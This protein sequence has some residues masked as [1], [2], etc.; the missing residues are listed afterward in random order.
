LAILADYLSMSTKLPK[1]KSSWTES[2]LSHHWFGKLLDILGYKSEGEFTYHTEQR[3]INSKTLGRKDFTLNGFGQ[4]LIM[5]ELKKPAVNLEPGHMDFIHFKQA[6]KY[7][8]SHY[9]CKKDFY[10]SPMGVLTNGIFAYLFDGSDENA[11]VAYERSLKLDLL[12]ENDLKKFTNLIQPSQFSKSKGIVH[13]KT[14]QV[15]PRPFIERKRAIG[16]ETW[17]AEKL[18]KIYNELNKCMDEKSAFAASITFF[19]TAILRDCGYIPTTDLNE[20]EDKKDWVGLIKI[21]EMHL[22]S[23][24]GG[25]LTLPKSKF[26]EAFTY[27]E[28]TRWLPVRLDVL[29]ADCLG[30]AY[31]K[32]LH[33]VKG[34]DAKTSYFTPRWLID[35]MIG[36]IGISKQHT[37]LDPTCGS[38]G[39]LTACIERAFPRNTAYNSTDIKKYIEKKLVGVD[40]DWF[41]VQ[42][43]KAALTAAYARY[44]PESPKFSAPKS[45][46]YEENIF[47]FKEALFKEGKR[48]TFD[49]II[50]NPPWESHTQWLEKKFHKRVKSFESFKSQAC[51]S[52]FV[53][54]ESA[55]LLKKNGKIGMVMKHEVLDGT[56]HQEFIKYLSKF[57]GV[58]WDFGRDKIFNNNSQTIVCFGQEGVPGNVQEIPRSPTARKN[59]KSFKYEGRTIESMFFTHKGFQS[60]ADPI[61]EMLAKQFPKSKHVKTLVGAS[62]IDSYKSKNGKKYF[63]LTQDD[64]LSKAEMEYCKKT[65]IEKKLRKSQYRTVEGLVKK[66]IK[67]FLHNRE[68]ILYKVAKAKERGEKF[69]PHF[70][71]A[72]FYKP[73]R[74][75]GAKNKIFIKRMISGQKRLKVC[76][77]KNK[78]VIT[79]TDVTVL[80]PKKGTT[81]SDIYFT[82]AFLNSTAAAIIAE[83]ELKQAGGKTSAA[84]PTYTK[85]IVVPN[86]DEE[87]VIDRNDKIVT[88]VGLKLV[89]FSASRILKA[90]P[91]NTQLKS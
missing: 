62:E 28:N 70:G 8:V 88:L 4:P 56:Q 20:C 69:K 23:D 36:E 55:K 13:L 61:F 64:K 37:V 79:K 11:N 22:N 24:L 73:D 12:K 85:K 90:C 46:I 66:S 72:R 42:V 91:T 51:I 41:A 57:S 52:I 75:F 33:L 67:W 31:E 48:K 50:G 74:C 14:S 60:A 89:I 44:L 45:T 81:E 1:V 78:D 58:I 86:A 84:F 80:I 26:D 49:R 10:A 59:K 63:F 35:E 30:I 87:V 47:D 16:A 65:I 9:V 21:L 76:L 71:W 19:L 27:Y 68:D 54:E 3:M 25:Y 32:L 43:S 53:F 39:F 77:I 7:A 2:D 29:P 82:L 83:K 18:K 15:I 17:L 34:K 6:H 38:S 40:K 5:V